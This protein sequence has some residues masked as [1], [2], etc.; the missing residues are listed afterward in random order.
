MKVKFEY[1]KDSA[2]F[3]FCKMTPEVRDLGDYIIFFC[4]FQITI[5]VN[6]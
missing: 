1:A 2:W 5:W 6:K 3:G 4:K